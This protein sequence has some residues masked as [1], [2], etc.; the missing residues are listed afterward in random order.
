[1]FHSGEFALDGALFGL[2]AAGFG[3]KVHATVT[4]LQRPRHGVARFGS[5]VQ[6]DLH[7]LSPW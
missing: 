4:S 2:A 6:N 5:V 7:G 1:M 3:M